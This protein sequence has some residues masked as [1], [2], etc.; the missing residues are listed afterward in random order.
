MATG[1]TSWSQSAA[2]NATA[3]SNVNAAEGMAPSQVDDSMRAMMSS[4]AKYRDDMNGTL[5]TG[6]TNT[7]YTITTNQGFASVSALS[8]QVLAIRFNATCGAAP[9]LAVDSLSAQPIQIDSITAVAKGSLRKQ[10]I[11][12]LTYDNAIPGFIVHN[13]HS[14]VEPG[15]LSTTA[16]SSAPPG[17]LL[18]DG[19][20]YSQ[21]TYADLFAAI[22]T[23]FGAA[24]G[25]FNVPD[26]RGRAPVGV[27]ASIAHLHNV[28]SL[29]ATTGTEAQTLASGN[30]PQ[31][32]FTPTG[33][34]ATSSNITHNAGAISGGVS[35][36]NFSALAG[37]Q[38]TPT[39]NAS[40]TGDTITIGSG[41][42][43]S[44]EIVQPV[45]ALNFIIKI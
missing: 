38:G 39:I 36:S 21:T 30:L 4:G 32:S 19:S 6:G 45:I 2:S 23:A 13:G 8:G 17:W 24:G 43:S 26:L 33:T 12:Y 3:D 35:G 37:D 5:T 31:Q 29:G 34:V 27:D 41:T 40:F 11:H 25:N 22:G 10:A 9:T 16:T 15:R 42:P 18:C 20:A 7:A 44:F 14:L 28:V 1:M